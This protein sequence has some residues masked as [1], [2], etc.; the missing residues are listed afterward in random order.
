[1]RHED[2]DLGK[3]YNP[4]GHHRKIRPKDTVDWILEEEKILRLVAERE[5]LKSW[6]LFLEV[7]GPKAFSH[8]KMVELERL[9]ALTVRLTREGKLVRVRSRQ[10]A[11]D[12]GLKL[13]IRCGEATCYLVLGPSY[14]PPYPDLETDQED[15]CR[16]IRDVDSLG[17]IVEKRGS[18]PEGWSCRFRR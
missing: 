6:D 5:I 14:V 8:E 10:I 3:G 11:K 16:P 13:P 12:L 2:L 1:M 17:S 9:M 15:L 4:W 7:I 18:I